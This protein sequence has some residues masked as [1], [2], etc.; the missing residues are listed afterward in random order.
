MKHLREL[1]KYSIEALSDAM[2]YLKINGC[3]R[4]FSPISSKKHIVGK[5]FTVKFCKNSN[6]E[7]C[8]AGDYID[9][10]DSNYIIVIDNNGLDYCTVWGN[11]LT[12]MA[13]IKKIRGTV[14]NGACRDQYAVKKMKYPLFSKFINCKTGKGIVKLESI[15]KD[16]T[17]DGVNI[18]Y[19]DYIKIVDG[20]LIVIPKEKIIDV[21]NIAKEVEKTEKKILS[22]ILT[23]M[24]LK[25]ARNKFNYNKYK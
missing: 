5:A 10:V 3:I 17:I 14:I 13:I 11:I 12:Q 9:E 19:G 2:D 7:V 4:G 22:A 23:G 1:K 24:S 18:A 15:K 25:E 6:P 20:V 8:I 16:I 21:L